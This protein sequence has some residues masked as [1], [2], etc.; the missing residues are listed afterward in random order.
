MNTLVNKKR[1]IDTFLRLVKVD[2]L[3]FKESRV[4]A[5]IKDELNSL[6]LKYYNAGKPKNGEAYNI[7]VD[8]PGNGCKKACLLLNAHVDTVSPGVNIRPKI[9]GEYIY[10]DGTTVLGADNKAGVAAI[11][12]ILAIIKENNLKHPPMQIIFTVAEEIGLMG[13]KAIPQKMLYAD[14]GIVLDGGD[15]NEI[16][17]KAPSQYN[18]TANIIGRAAHAGIHPEEGISA[19]TVASHAIAKMKLGRIDKDTTAN[20]GVIKGGSA[21]NIIPEAVELKGEAR[22]HGLKKL[23]KQVE[24]MERI[25]QRTCNYYHARLELE[26][27]KMY[28]SFCM[29]KSSQLIKNACAGTAQ[30]KIRPELKQTGGG[31]DANIFNAFGI[32]TIIMGVGADHVHTKDE[33]IAINDL[34]TGTQIVLNTI[35]KCL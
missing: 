10:S 27:K 2:S 24:H 25:L 7:M 20:I 15:I 17:Y 21:T 13:A 18:I 30:Q 1:L 35:Q 34:V 22:S 16:I 5:L 11:L 29:S 14:L 33:R 32:P 6:R 4:M 19:I 9:I 23:E 8:V 28:Q 31:S 12:E 26:I 3:S